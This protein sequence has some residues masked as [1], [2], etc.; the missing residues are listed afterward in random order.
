[1]NP[2]D[3][4]SFTFELFDDESFVAVET[5]TK[6]EYAR[7]DRLVGGA[8]ICDD[9]VD[10]RSRAKTDSSVELIFELHPIGRTATNEQVIVIV[11]GMLLPIGGTLLKRKGKWYVVRCSEY[12]VEE[13]KQKLYER[14]ESR[15]AE[16]KADLE[17]SN[18]S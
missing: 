1:M 8:K 6:E 5:R 3:L 9:A 7:L 11:E 4:S 16:L 18:G 2:I 14:L 13:M 17:R 15:K 12:A 10:A